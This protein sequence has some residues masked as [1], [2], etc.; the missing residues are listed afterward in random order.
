MVDLFTDP[1][2]E[3]LKKLKSTLATYHR[4][5]VSS[6][7]SNAALTDLPLPQ[8][9]DPAQKVDLPSRFTALWL[10]LKDSIVAAIQLPIFLLPFLTHLPVYVVGILGARLVEDEMETQAQMKVAFG[11]LLSF[12]TYPV[13][14]F[15]FWAIFRAWTLGAAIAAGLVWLLGRYHSAFIDQNYNA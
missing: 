12:L 4:L 10:L 3:D 1:S 9:L 11:L 5:L 13:L 14:F 15:T 2:N 6:R 7:L 8:T